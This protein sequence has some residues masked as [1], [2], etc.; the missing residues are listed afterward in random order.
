MIIEPPAS[1]RRGASRRLPARR[2]R[3]AEPLRRKAASVW[4]LG[5]RS[6]RRSCRQR[7][8]SGS[9]AVRP[10]D[11][12]DRA[13]KERFAERFLQRW[14]QLRYRLHRRAATSV[15]TRLSARHSWR[16][17]VRRTRSRGI[18]RRSVRGT[19]SRQLRS[20]TT[21]AD[22]TTR[23]ATG[24]RKVEMA[25]AIPDWVRAKARGH[26]RA[27]LRRRVRCDAGE[28]GRL[29]RRGAPER[30]ARSSRRSSSRSSRR[31]T[32][33]RSPIRVE[34]ECWSVSGGEDSNL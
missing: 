9:Q 16:S 13:W 25:A 19:S 31:R 7:S 32:R 12:I 30:R 8:S 5:D 28:R 10:S 1:R 11:E 29:A 2:P 18:R 17:M 26:G 6:S 15:S 20:E 14:R 3:R 34:E 33:R 22:R 24:A 4:R 21:T 27:L 23:H